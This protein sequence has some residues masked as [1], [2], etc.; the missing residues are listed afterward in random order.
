MPFTATLMA[1]SLVSGHAGVDV[2]CTGNVLSGVDC[3]EN[4]PAAARWRKALIAS[5]L[6]IERGPLSGRDGGPL[7]LR[8]RRIE[9]DVVVFWLT[10]H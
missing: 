4:D 2:G 3:S 5:K 7:S 10:S 8:E 9:L 6:E 1:V